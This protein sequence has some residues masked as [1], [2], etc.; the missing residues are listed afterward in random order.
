MPRR[1]GVVHPRRQRRQHDQRLRAGRLEHQP[2]VFASH[3]EL[4]H[5][6]EI[7]ARHFLAAHRDGDAGVELREQTD[8][9]FRRDAEILRHR[10][11]VGETGVDRESGSSSAQ[12]RPIAIHKLRLNQPLTGS[13]LSELERMMLDAGVGTPADLT[14]AKE[15]SSGLGAVRRATTGDALE[16]GEGGAVCAELQALQRAR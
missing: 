9:V 12:P 15:Q 10:E 11:H 13:D 5:R 3:G 16:R 14:R 4:E 8:R 7:A 2:H 6:R 1:D